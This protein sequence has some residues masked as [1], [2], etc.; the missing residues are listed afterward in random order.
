[1]AAAPIFVGTIKTAAQ[2]FVNADG[3]ATKSV[4]TAGTAGAKIQFLNASSDD[5]SARVVRLHIQRG[6]AGTDYLIGSVTVA[7]G[8]GTGAV[9]SANLLVASQI[10]G[11]LE[12]GTIILGPSDVLKCAV[13][14]AVTAAKTLTVFAQGGD[15]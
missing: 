15:Y 11:V 13:E 2:T 5:T 9:A 14:S 12:D 4:Y 8:A 7:I 10:P 6:G 3:T 1:M